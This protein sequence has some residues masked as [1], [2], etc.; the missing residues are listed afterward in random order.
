MLGAAIVLLAVALA[1]EG[2][3]RVWLRIVHRGVY[4]LDAELGWM[5]QANRRFDTLTDGV[6]ATFTTNAL[7]LRGP[8]PADTSS[9]TVV[10]LGDSFTQGCQV[11]DAELFTTLWQAARPD[12]AIVN[13]GVGG[14][15]TVQESLLLRRRV[16]TRVHPDLVVVMAY[17]NDLTDNVMPF[18]PGLGPRPYMEPDGTIRPLDWQPFAPLLPEVPAREWLYYRSRAVQLWQA[19]RQLRP[20]RTRA[21]REQA[22]RWQARTTAADRWRILERALA[23]LT[24]APVVLVAI[25]R[26]RDVRLANVEFTRGLAEIAGRLG[27]G[28]VDIQS[29][30]RPEH[31]YRRNIHWNAA[32][33]RTVGE[34]LAAAIR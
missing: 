22:A 1:V 18:Y 5:P 12:L 28:F 19:R 34:R 17:A 10:V 16:A 24:E 20:R 21:A 13:A 23:T 11:S 25:P 14:Y 30:L 8:L 26:R 3:V 33:H 15:G 27:V 6:P 9:R 4:V 7:G 2:A 31:Y 32:G 29:S